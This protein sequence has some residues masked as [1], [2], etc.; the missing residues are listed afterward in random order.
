MHTARSSNLP[1]YSAV[2]DA[3]KRSE[4][5]V[6]FNIYSSEDV[7]VENGRQW[8][9]VSLINSSRIGYELAEQGWGED[10][11][12][13]EEQNPQAG[14]E[15]QVPVPSLLKVA[16]QLQDD[17]SKKLVNYESSEVHLILPN[18]CYGQH[19]L[20]D[21]MLQDLENLNC[22]LTLSNILVQA[23]SFTPELGARL[24]V[25]PYRDFTE[26]VNLDCTI[27]L[28]LISD[29]SHGPVDV[30]P[31][32]HDAVRRQCRT[33][34]N[35]NLLPSKLWPALEGRDMECTEDAAE[36]MKEIV[37]TIGT[38]SEKARMEILMSWNRGQETSFELRESLQ[39]TSTYSI[40]Q[41]L[42][43]PI[44]AVN[45]KPE[46]LIPQLPSSAKIL[47]SELEGINR[48][49]FFHGWSRGITTLTSNRHVS[50]R[51]EQ[52]IG[53]FK[54]RGPRVWLCNVARSLIGREK[55][56]VKTTMRPSLRQEIFGTVHLDRS[57]LLL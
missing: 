35:A 6:G 3:A 14:D 24:A 16:Q 25:N 26:V 29:L 32:F 9:K 18:L 42:R 52:I 31:W 22:I 39:A 55:E 19:V 53:G 34:E 41:S 56:K 8:L 28:A 2:W 27:L 17:A 43:L 51:I 36:R 33:E 40:P 57:G 46:H 13:E 10:F 12:P 50:K 49:V 37:R 44:K 11:S 21:K 23:P 47:L 30:E 48:S 15:P 38:D 5:V 45:V 1:F 7:V 54:E 4:G 20:I